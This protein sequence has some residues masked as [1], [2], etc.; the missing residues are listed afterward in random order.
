[1]SSNTKVYEEK[2]KSSV[3]H[4]GRELA[5]NLHCVIDVFTHKRI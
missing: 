5:D 2:M 3:E 4:L 1:M